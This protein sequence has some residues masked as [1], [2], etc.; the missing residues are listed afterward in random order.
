MDKGNFLIAVLLIII[1]AGS[2]T[3]LYLLLR[4]DRDAIT[5]GLTERSVAIWAE[6]TPDPHDEFFC[7]ICLRDD[8]PE[9]AATNLCCKSIYCAECMLAY[10]SSAG[11][12]T[13]PVCR[14]EIRR[15][16]IFV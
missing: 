9:S 14:T 10:T 4:K 2:A 12:K 13:C 15:A 5:P 1:I 6:F 8:P 11:G 16:G 7:P 3:A